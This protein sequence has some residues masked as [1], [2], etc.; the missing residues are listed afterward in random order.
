MSSFHP[1]FALAAGWPVPHP[2]GAFSFL[3]CRYSKPRG[4]FVLL[5]MARLFVAGFLLFD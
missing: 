5:A 2:R 4:G 3:P 1:V